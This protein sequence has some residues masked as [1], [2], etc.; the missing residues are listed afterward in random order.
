M[1]TTN[2]TAATEAALDMEALKEALQG[3]DNFDPAAVLPQ[4]DSIF[5]RILLICRVCV[6]LGPVILLLLGLG[7]LFLA[8]KEANYYFGYR[9]FFGMG[10]VMAWQFTQRMAGMVL[11]GLGLV[12]TV[13]MVVISTGFPGMETEA[14]AW[15]TVKCLIWQV[16]LTLLATLT[17]N[18]LAMFW[19]NRK[20]ELRR[21]PPKKA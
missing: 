3:L 18:G 9:C 21:R 15:L 17:I 12:L 11:G 14:M 20:G 6:L 19:F 13:V 7:Y 5:G 2:P 1:L 10:S 8:P 16:V 4:M